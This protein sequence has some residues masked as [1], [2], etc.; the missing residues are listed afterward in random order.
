MSD[1][2]ANTNNN[3]PGF[4]NNEPQRRLVIVTGD[5]GGVGKSTF[6]RGLLQLYINKDLVCLAYEADQRNPQLERHYVDKYR[7][8]IRYIDIFRKGEA[9]KLLID[10]EKEK[11]F[12]LFL[13]D[14]PAQSGGFFENY[15]KELTFFEM[16]K[17]VN[18]QVT[19]VSVISRVQDSVNVLEKLHE[20]CK[21]QVDYVV[22]KNLFHGESDKFER[23]NDS[24]IRKDMSSKGL[25]EIMMPELFYLP[26]DFLDY[27]ALTFNDA[28]THEKTNL[29]I[30]AR[31]KYWLADFEEKTKS[32]FHLLGFDKESL[33]GYYDKMAEETKKAK[34][35][36]K[37]QSKSQPTQTPEPLQNSA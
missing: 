20:L 13:L 34:N 25:V 36:E 37:K 5:K 19:M 9:D 30:K 18:C 11:Q 35:K 8:L 4:T 14:L 27:Y 12:S 17:D 26:Y 21:D 33:S 15:V 28:L 16:L 32:A 1:K 24:K 3:P 29:V 10:I 6:A 2:N 23:Y 22:V 31:V 7:P